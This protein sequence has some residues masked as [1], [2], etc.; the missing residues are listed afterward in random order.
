[1][2]L[3]IIGCLNKLKMSCK[4]DANAKKMGD[5]LNK[6]DTKTIL[7]RALSLVFEWASEHRNELLEDWTLCAQHQVPKKIPPLE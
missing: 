7:E 4:S 1:M 6:F 3:I 2:E 5:E